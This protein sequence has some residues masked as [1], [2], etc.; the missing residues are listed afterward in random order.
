MMSEI[1]DVPLPLAA[2]RRLINFLTF[3][4]SIF[5]SA[6]FACGALIVGDECSLRKPGGGS[7]FRLRDETVV[8]DSIEMLK[9]TVYFLILA[10]GLT[11]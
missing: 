9:Q 3:H 11:L 5:F 8:S 10:T 7:L 6:S 2:S 1:M 4:I